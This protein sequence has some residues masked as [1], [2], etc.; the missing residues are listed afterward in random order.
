M[1]KG[2][3][4]KLVLGPLWDFDHAIGNDGT[5][6]DNATAGWEYAE[7]A[8]TERFYADPRFRSKMAR[9]W[10]AMRDQ[11]IERHLMETIDSGAAQLAGAA[12]RNFSRWR[13]FGTPRAKPDDPRTGAPPAN[14]AQAVDYLKWWL[15]ERIKWMDGS[16]ASLSRS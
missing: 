12:D 5:P 6:V 7:S 1:Y 4:E 16:I 9:H 11:G 14:H 2:V 3:G 13:I 15:R 10:Q 8:W